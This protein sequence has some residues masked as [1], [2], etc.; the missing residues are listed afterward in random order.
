MWSETHISS[1]EF[2]LEFSFRLLHM[3]GSSGWNVISKNNVYPAHT[4]TFEFTRTNAHTPPDKDNSPHDDLWC[5][6]IFVRNFFDNDVPILFL[7]LK[8]QLKWDFWR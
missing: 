5:F 4:Q 7:K 6:L 3:N 8:S 1:Y 2:L